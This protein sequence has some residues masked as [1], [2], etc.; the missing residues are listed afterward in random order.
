MR[1]AMRRQFNVQRAQGRLEVT[2]M[3]EW[4]E[5]TVSPCGEHASRTSWLRVLSQPNLTSCPSPT[6][7]T[8]LTG[9]NTIHPLVCFAFCHSTS[10]SLY[11]PFNLAVVRCLRERGDVHRH[12]PNHR[13]CPDQAQLQCNSPRCNPPHRQTLKTEPRIPQA[14]L[15]RFST[16]DLPMHPQLSHTPKSFCL[17]HLRTTLLLHCARICTSSSTSLEAP[18]ATLMVAP[19]RDPHPPSDFT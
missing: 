5:P 7:R 12:I 10:N 4:K 11:R 19:A 8:P 13:H 9:S 14:I 16:C 1:C 3:V 18:S 6:T 17:S 2:V 15:L